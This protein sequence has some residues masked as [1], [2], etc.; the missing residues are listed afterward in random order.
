MPRSP[1][2]ERAQ[3]ALEQYVA[4][5]QGIF[6]LMR[7]GHSWS[8]RERH[9]VFLNCGDGRFADVSAVTGLDFLDD[10]R[11]FGVVDGTTTETS[12]C[13]CTIAPGRVCA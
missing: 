4:S 2:A 5:W 9:Q 8:G 13:G 12:I 7:E 6:R 10:G 11:A 3:E 1:K